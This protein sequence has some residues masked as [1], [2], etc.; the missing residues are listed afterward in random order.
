MKFFN[1]KVATDQDWTKYIAE[2][3][4]TRKKDLLLRCKKYSVSI[5]IDDSA[6]N[7]E[8]IYGSLRAVASEAEL[9]RRLLARES[10]NN[11]RNANIISFLA[12][13]IS[14]IALIKS[15]K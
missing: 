11:T 14:I 15:F 13:L 10:T 3:T 5:Y 9:E 2:A 8:G 6:E 1:R 7:S 4:T 12:L